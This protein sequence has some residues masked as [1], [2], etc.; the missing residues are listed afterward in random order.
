MGCP[1]GRVRFCWEGAGR[2][3]RE[4]GEGSEGEGE[5]FGEGE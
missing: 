5:R 2:G 4:G 3:G 1:E